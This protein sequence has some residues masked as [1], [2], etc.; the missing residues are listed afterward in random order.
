MFQIHQHGHYHM[1]HF[2]YPGVL[3]SKITMAF[4]IF[5]SKREHVHMHM[6]F[7][8]CMEYV[9]M[10]FLAQNRRFLLKYQH[11]I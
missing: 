7:K 8:K 2:S 4:N 6:K 10:F 1:H 5:P 3:K 11:A 9:E